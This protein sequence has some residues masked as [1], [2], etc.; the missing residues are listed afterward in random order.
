MP[1]VAID[2]LDASRR[3]YNHNDTLYVAFQLMEPSCRVV[4]FTISKPIIDGLV[5][6]ILGAGYVVCKRSLSLGKVS[7]K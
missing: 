5:P 6:F 4:Y 2:T 3:A 7:A 1:V